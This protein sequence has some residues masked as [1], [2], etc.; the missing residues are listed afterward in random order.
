MLKLVF[1]SSVV[2]FLLTEVTPRYVRA[3]RVRCPHCIG[4][5]SGWE[6]KSPKRS[7]L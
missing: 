7:F 1:S 6:R 4:A 3:R 5:I 2:F